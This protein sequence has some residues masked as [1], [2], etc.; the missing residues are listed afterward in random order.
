LDS[1]YGVKRGKNIAL[2]GKGQERFI[3]FGSIGEGYSEGVIRTV[4]GGEKYA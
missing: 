2:R 4:L 1:G 3:R